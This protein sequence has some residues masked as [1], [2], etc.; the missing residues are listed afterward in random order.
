MGNTRSDQRPV[1]RKSRAF[2]VV[3]M[4]PHP[5]VIFGYG[6][7]SRQYRNVPIEP[8]SSVGERLKLTKRT[9]FQKP[10]YGLPDYEVRG[11]FVTSLDQ[12]NDPDAVAEHDVWLDLLDVL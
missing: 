5:L 6:N 12:A 10:R 7:P 9:Y 2:V 4:A 1:T 11:F 3:E 8:K